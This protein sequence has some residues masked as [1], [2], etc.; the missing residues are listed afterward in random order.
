MEVHQWPGGYEYENAR[1]YSREKTSYH[2][3][4]IPATFI[5]MEI[6]EIPMTIPCEAWTCNSCEV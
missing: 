1:R 4:F 6:V 2:L 3:I 5:Q